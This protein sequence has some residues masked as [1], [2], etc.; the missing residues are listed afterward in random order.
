MFFNF[1]QHVHTDA[2]S[3]SDHSRNFVGPWFNFLFFNNG[4]HTA[5]HDDP[6]LHWSQLPKAHSA[7]ADSI[8]PQLNQRNLVVF[9]F[10]QY[11]VALFWPGVGTAQIGGLPSNQSGKCVV[12]APKIQSAPEAPKPV[13]TMHS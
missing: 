3:E 11:F 6:A 1:I 9:L 4:Y 7:I 12:P 10:R 13:N 8:D 2:W 5:H